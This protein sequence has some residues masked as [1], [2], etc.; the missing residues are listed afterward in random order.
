MEVS[1]TVSSAL[2]NP[3][4]PPSH[5]LVK[6]GPLRSHASMGAWRVSDDV[7]CMHQIAL[8]LTLASSEVVA[9]T[10]PPPIYVRSASP[11]S[12]RS[13]CCSVSHSMDYSRGLFA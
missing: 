10:A 8:K 3:A 6:K 4:R 2:P 9:V 13:A 5:C 1:G 12:C 11:L 7:P